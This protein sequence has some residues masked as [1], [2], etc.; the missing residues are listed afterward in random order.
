MLS[1]SQAHCSLHLR[2]G[3]YLEPSSRPRKQELRLQRIRHVRPKPCKRQ[4]PNSAYS[5]SLEQRTT[6]S[7]PALTAASTPASTVSKPKLSIILYPAQPKKLAEN[8]ER[9][10]R[11]AKLPIV[12]INTF[13]VLPLFSV[14][15]RKASN[16][17][18]PRRNLE[19]GSLP[20]RNDHRHNSKNLFLESYRQLLP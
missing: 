9:A 5:S 7:A 1:M 17:E 14:V 11:I 16:S 15:I 20:H 6:I 10:K 2:T 13:G 19:P 18:A 3:R 4:E 12:N 8:C